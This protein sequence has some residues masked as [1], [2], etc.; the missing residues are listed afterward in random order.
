MGKQLPPRTSSQKIKLEAEYITLP[1]DQNYERIQRLTRKILRALRFLE[2]SSE[3]EGAY[4]NPGSAHSQ[5]IHDIPFATDFEKR[6][7]I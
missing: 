6:L 3:R 4:S 7:G 5:E 1:K 2:G